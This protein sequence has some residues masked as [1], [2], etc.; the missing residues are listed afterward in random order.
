MAPLP[1]QIQMAD[2]ELELELE[3]VRVDSGSSMYASSEGG[4]GSVYSDLGDSGILPPLN[5]GGGWV[6]VRHED[7]EDREIPRR[8]AA[9]GLSGGRGW[10]GKP[11]FFEYLYG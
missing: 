9:M 2:P 10:E 5:G 8:S 7:M 3:L 6:A 1:T 11:S 4:D